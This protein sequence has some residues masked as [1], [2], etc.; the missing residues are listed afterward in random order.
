MAEAIG[1]SG[2]GK[3]RPRPADRVQGSLR[4]DWLIVALS[5]WMVG[6]MHLDAW[7]HHI[8]EIETFFTPWHA[9]LYT[10][11]LALAATISGYWIRSLRRG[12][13][14]E[15]ALPVGYSLSLLG[16]GLFTIG[17]VGD[18]LWHLAFGIE[19]NI[20]ALL[21]PTH[22]LLGF[23]GA[24]IATGPLRAAWARNE[25]APSLTSLLPGLLS[26]SLLLAAL[27]FFTIFANP[28]SDAELATGARPLLDETA[29]A[30]QA[31]GI[32]AILVQTTIMMGLI[33]LAKKRWRLPFGSVT[34]ILTVSATL[35]VA[36]HEDFHLLVIALLTGLAADLMMRYLEA[37]QTSQRSF[38]LFS[39]SVPVVYYVLYFATLAIGGEIWWS[40]HI[41]AG[42][43]V[44]AGIAGWLISYA[45][46][47]PDP[48]AW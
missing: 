13:R 9:A 12:F 11:F 36:V 17:A 24:L 23:G 15:N 20:E 29:F 34:L 1:L 6:G 35:T 16:V 30:A 31:L 27:T 25:S 41:W 38:R 43:I 40:I 48:K 28:L 46:L 19:D 7:A 26:L 3:I 44:I 39:L 32:A 10:G 5:L 37:D 45:F 33:L 18:M 42:A 4:F 47:P 14:W 21:S 22:L 2:Q 8:V